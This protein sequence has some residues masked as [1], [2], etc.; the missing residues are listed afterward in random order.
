[1]NV[2]IIED[3]DY[4]KE[5]IS[6][7]IRKKFNNNNISISVAVSLSEAIN[8]IDNSNFDLIFVDMAIPSHKA[9]PGEGTAISFLTGGIDV[10][11]ELSE[12]ERKDKCIV[13]TQHPSIEISGEHY[14]LDIAP[15]KFKELLD[16]D[17]LACIHYIEDDSSWKKE[18]RKV[19]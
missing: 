18:L 10:L 3:D 13:I 16:C 12:T 14:P 9:E 2:L 1:M 11:I 6:K 7:F 17:V 15:L 8:A 5:N 4:K 19:I